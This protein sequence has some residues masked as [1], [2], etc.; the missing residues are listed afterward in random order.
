MHRYAADQL[1]VLGG[2]LVGLPLLVTLARRQVEH[3][4]VSVWYVMAAY[5]WF[6][7]IFI[8]GNWPT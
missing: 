5:V 6:P 2:G 4:Y 3:L 7:V 8:A 1:L